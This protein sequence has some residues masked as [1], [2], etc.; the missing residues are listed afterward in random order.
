MP[1]SVNEVQ[2][3]LIVIA[4]LPLDRPP[5]SCRCCCPPSPPMPPCPPPGAFEDV[6]VTQQFGGGRL[7]VGPAQ[8]AAWGVASV[9]P[10]Q[11]RF[12]RG[13]VALLRCAG[14][15]PVLQ[16]RGQRPRASAPSRA[17]GTDPGSSTPAVCRL[18]PAAY[19]LLPSP[20]L[21]PATVLRETCGRRPTP[22]PAAGAGPRGSPWWSGW[23]R[24]GTAG[25]PGPAS[26][27]A[28]RWRRRPA[29]AA[30]AAAAR[31]AAARTAAAVAAA[32]ALP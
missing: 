27:G 19:R 17:R 2:K 22:S 28:S 29:A 14:G 31:T 10:G 26:S 30:A 8:L 9:A 13:G 16:V 21:S 25:A 15:P 23:P 7:E 12:S 11:L 24:R 6:A 4:M 18:P 5:A 20:Q 32:A 3:R 1:S